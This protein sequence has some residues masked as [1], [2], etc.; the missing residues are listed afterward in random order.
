MSDAI[1]QELDVYFPPFVT[2][3]I[4]CCLTADYEDIPPLVSDSDY[5]DMPPLVSDNDYSDS[6]VSSFI[7]GLLDG[8][9]HT[10]CDSSLRPQ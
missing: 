7:A 2:N 10:I 9:T 6:E 3:I 1:E 5:E 8:H 4:S